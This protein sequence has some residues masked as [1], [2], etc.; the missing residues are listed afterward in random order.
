M[1]GQHAEAARQER[2]ATAGVRRKDVRRN[3]V[4]LVAA[5]VAAGLGL[6]A[7]SSGGSGG[8]ASSSSGKSGV[9][10]SASSSAAPAK[11]KTT[12]CPTTPGP[13][14]LPG[15]LP[16]GG[17]GKPGGAA[18][19]IPVAKTIKPSD[20]S[21]STVITPGGAQMRC[22]A[23]RITTTK[24]VVYSTPT[25]H[26]K[27]TQLKLDIQVPATAGRKP[28]VVYITGGGFVM[29][30]KTANLDQRTYVA[31]Q[32]YVVASIQYRTTAS[33]GA[34]Y[35]DGVADVKSAVRYLRAHADQFGIDAGEVA[36]WGQSAGGYLA[37]M[38]GTTNG[39]KQYDTG[40]DLDQSSEVQCVVDEFGPADLSELAADYDTAAQKANYTAGNSAAQ[41]VYGP[42]TEKSVAEH[43]SQVAA[44]DPA[45]HITSKT[46]PF[47]LFHGSSDHLV[48]PSQT[49]SLHN[50]LRA[51]G[52]DSTRYVLAG[53]DHG[54][55]SFTGNTKAALPWSTQ[56]TMGHLVAFLAQHL[57][58]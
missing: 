27:K 47:V 9:S 31:D 1:D 57:A 10:A 54:D 21:T 56:E 44:A 17:S 45:T 15:G 29:A 52:I 24:D 48:S 14:G 40:G 16:P 20:T 37:A 18:G 43:T 28:L 41:W 12:N 2:Q 23:T 19:G 6:A 58:G 3:G 38:T 7:C 32:G 36:V 42:G 39:D 5:T 11:A 25:T 35:K 55:L 4:A 50:S 22:D 34:T 51:K 46:P 33:D 30:D 26:G 53:A 13:S 8:S 49:L